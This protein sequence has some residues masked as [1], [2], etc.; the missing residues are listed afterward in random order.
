LIVDGEGEFD[1]D[2]FVLGNDFKV[3]YEQLLETY[4]GGQCDMILIKNVPTTSKGNW[5]LRAHQYTILTK[6][7]DE[8]TWVRLLKL[9]NKLSIV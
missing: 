7:V 5:Y 2:V 3:E 9:H 4:N 6:I 8:A 1:W